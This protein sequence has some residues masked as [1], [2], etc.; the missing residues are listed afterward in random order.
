MPGPLNEHD[1][2]KC[3]GIFFCLSCNAGQRCNRENNTIWL[4]KPSLI[5]LRASLWEDGSQGNKLPW[6]AST[7]KLALKL[8]KEKNWTHLR[9]SLASIGLRTTLYV[10]STPFQPL[11]NVDTGKQR[12]PDG[13]TSM[14]SGFIELTGNS[15]CRRWTIQMLIQLGS[16]LGGSN[17]ILSSDNAF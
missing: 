16:H 17:P 15:F 2:P 8:E 14:I 5:L 13:G 6:A 1:L 4:P 12:F 7:H 3:S 9:I 10:I 11:L